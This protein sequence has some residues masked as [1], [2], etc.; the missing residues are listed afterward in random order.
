VAEA[1]NPDYIASASSEQGVTIISNSNYSFRFVASKDEDVITVTNASTG[2]PIKFK[3]ID[4][5]GNALA[6]A[7]F[8]LYTDTSWTPLQISGAAVTGTS[9]TVNG[10]DGIVSLEKIPKGVYYMKETG[11]PSGYVNGNTYIL[12][13][14]DKALAKEELDATAT[15]YLSGIATGDIAAQTALYKS[16]YGDDY[17]KYAIF[18][19][20][21]AAAVTTPD[22]ATYGIMNISTSQ[23][24]AIL[25]KIDQTYTPLESAVFD[26]L[27]Y[28]RTVVDAMLSSYASGVF[29]IG[30]LPYGTYYLHETTV[31]T[32]FSSLSTGDN[33]FVLTVD[34]DGVHTPVRLA[35]A[36]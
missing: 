4:G 30:Q 9:A 11:T 19:I 14:G 5:Y 33:W 18:L 21:G 23:R 28:D 36:P 3:K 34:G 22:I 25:E 15:A 13:V 35:A 7:T 10:T 8:S 31:P 2:V 24:K 29:W 26:I 20:D 17:G 27:R 32:G 12:L 16:T 6:S 1:E